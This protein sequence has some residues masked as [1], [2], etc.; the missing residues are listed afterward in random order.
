M[1]KAAEQGHTQ[2]QYKLADC[3]HAGEGVRKDEAKAVYWLDKSA[4]QGWPEAQGELGW[5]YHDGIPAI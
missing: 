3:Y 4:E 5:A 1:K 2:T